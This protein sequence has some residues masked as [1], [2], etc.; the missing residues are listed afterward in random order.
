[1]KQVL[2]GTLETYFETGMECLGLILYLEGDEYKTKNP[3]YD[4]NDSK[5]GPD[6]YKSH[7]GIVYLERGDVLEL[8]DGTNRKFTIGNRQLASKDKYR[9][10]AYPF[11]V[12][13]LKE[14]VKLFLSETIQAQVIREVKK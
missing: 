2:K 5:K 12:I 4:P 6:F 7:N 13:D 1:M 14:W 8:L 9:V 10:S 3:N 11:E